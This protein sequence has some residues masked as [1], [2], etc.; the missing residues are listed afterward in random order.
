MDN[1][2]STRRHRRYRQ[3]ARLFVLATLL[4]LG[5]LHS[6]TVQSQSWATKGRGGNIANWESGTRGVINA[7][8]HS[9]RWKHG[10]FS[11]RKTGNLIASEQLNSEAATTVTGCGASAGNRCGDTLTYGAWEVTVTGFDVRFEPNA[12]AINA[13]PAGN[14]VTATLRG[15]AETLSVSIRGA[16]KP[17]EFAATH[18]NQ[19]TVTEGGDSGT[20]PLP[21]TI[22]TNSAPTAAL[23]VT[24]QTSDGATTRTVTSSAITAASWS[25]MTSQALQNIVFDNDDTDDIDRQLTFTATAVDP[26]H[27]ILP[28]RNT[29]VFNIKDDDSPQI[30]IA[31][32]TANE[33]DG[34]LVFDVAL[35]ASD[36]HGATTTHEVTVDYATSIESGQTAT[37]GTD[38]DATDGTLTIPA[39][40]TGGKITVTI[41][42]DADSEDETFTLTLSNPVN[43]LASSKLAAVGTIAEPTPT[44]AISPPD[45]T[46]G[47]GSGNAALTV[48]LT[49]SSSVATTVQYAT[50]NGTAMAGMDYTET[51]GTLSFAADDTTKTIMV[52][53]NDD[54]RAGEDDETFSV[55]LS[56][57]SNSTPIGNATATVTITDNDPPTVF[58]AFPEAAENNN[59][60]FIARL[61]SDSVG[62]GLVAINADVTLQWQTTTGGTATADTDYTAVTA[63]TL[64][65]PAGSSTASL[66]V[67]VIDD[68]AEEPDETVVVRFSNLSDNAIFGDNRTF[69]NATGT[70]LNND[71]EPFLVIGDARAAEDAGMLNFIARLVDANGMPTTFGS[72]VTFQYTTAENRTAPLQPGD[73][74]DPD[75]FTARAN[76]MVTISANDPSINIAV[77]IF[78]NTDPEGNKTFTLTVAATSVTGAKLVGNATLLTAI[79]TILDDE[80]AFSIANNIATAEASGNIAIQVTL[81]PAQTVA[82]TVRYTITEGTATA[83]TDYTAASSGTL[84]FAAGDTVQTIPVTIEQDGIANEGDETFTVTLDMASNGISIAPDTATVTITDNDMQPTVTAANVRVNEGSPAI[85]NVRLLDA[86]SEMA[87]ASATAITIDYRTTETL[88]VSASGNVDYVSDSGI[89]TFAPGTQS[90]AIAIATSTD[91]VVDPNEQFLLILN[92]LRG[93]A[94][95]EGG[96]TITALTVTATI[97]EGLSDAQMKQLNEA[98]TP[99]VIAAMTAAS[100][101]ILQNRIDTALS[102]G[103]LSAATALAELIQQSTHGNRPASFALPL[104]AQGDHMP[105]GMHNLTLWGQAYYREIAG[106]Q[107]PI[108][109]DGDLTGGLIGMDARMHNWLLGL[110]FHEAQAEL[111][112]DYANISGSHTTR[113]S[114]IRPYAAWVFGHHQLWGS[115]G[116]ENGHLTITEPNRTTSLDVKYRS[117]QLGGISQLA[118]GDGN[119]SLI[120]DTAYARLKD[121]ETDSFASDTGWL[122]L[123]MKYHQTH[124][125][126]Q[127]RYADLSFRHDYGDSI[128]G[129]GLELGGG[130]DWQYPNGLQ[131]NLDAR[132]LLTH[133]DDLNEWGI[134][135]TLAWQPNPHGHGL[136]LRLQPQWGNR[137]SKQQP[138]W[139]EGSHALSP[140]ATPQ[141][142]Y[143][144]AL[145]YAIPTQHEDALLTL[146]ARNQGSVTKLGGHYQFNETLTAGFEALRQ[147]H[148][149]PTT[150]QRAW[151]KLRYGF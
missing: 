51:S 108:D 97:T 10:Y 91:T 99:Q 67:V 66:T 14:T 145:E 141:A 16:A 147:P 68:A 138:L 70:I 79:G 57:A 55:T 34:E 71:T 13:L 37:E 42:P 52:P 22:S 28:M 96:S 49:P 27:T 85:F 25:S 75:D 87:I 113:L 62:G 92:N 1:L 54:D 19:V 45:L 72:D 15:G 102:G 36:S 33:N 130:A 140:T 129:T 3:I 60:V 148:T 139:H 127:S 11:S 24:Y 118:L 81:L 143:A 35:S 95:F 8:R 90:I 134:S 29:I 136:S 89:L 142:R 144:M 65:I 31:D 128:N 94:M 56:N 103:Q 100:G 98:T 63:Q 112:F 106:E 120:G 61:E 4:G 53:I 48:T 135:G 21:I 151:L 133:T 146:F 9:F 58:V 132:A 110:A 126:K 111:D 82:N 124:T 125:G 107:T 6:A 88:P 47:E 123:G 64:T 46:V 59:L 83:G 17:F 115:L 2:L 84:N 73:A 122:R 131:F 78:D 93:D 74:D 18:S 116:L 20:T 101:H 32:A 86:I 150:D 38:F 44:F 109:F 7:Q 80:L 105:N 43:A 40:G 149:I 50:A 76:Q 39:N 23:S 69:I 137:Q 26:S 104:Q 114:G 30:A 119:F 12:A 41:K 121:T 5:F 117:F 77:P